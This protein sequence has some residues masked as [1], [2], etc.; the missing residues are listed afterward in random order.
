MVWEKFREDFG[1][2]SDESE[3]EEPQF[4][5]VE[6]PLFRRRLGNCVIA[7]SEPESSRFIV[8]YHYTNQ[9]G[10]V[11]S[12]RTCIQIRRIGPISPIWRSDT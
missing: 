6:S 10:G 7:F 8:V 9:T 5:P 11:K 2:Q 12:T 3:D 1:S 4:D